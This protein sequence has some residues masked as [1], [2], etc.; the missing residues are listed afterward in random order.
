LFGW[1]AMTTRSPT[2]NLH[3]SAVG[4]RPALQAVASRPA[5]KPVIELDE[6]RRRFGDT[7][8]LDGVSLTIASGEVHALLGPNG[9]GKTTLIRLLAGLAAPTGGTLRLFGETR[10]RPREL[11]AR[12][13]FV[14]SG[15]RTFYLRLSGLEN[16]R[17][18]ARLHGFSRR[19][20][21]AV[22]RS[23]L[24]DVGLDHAAHRPV[25]SW[26][27]G[28]QK[29]LSIARALVTDP[30][31]LLVDEAT[32]DLDPEASETV[33]R[34]VS[35]LAERGTAVLWATQRVDEIRGFAD[36]VTFLAGGTVRFSGS[37][38]HLI[39]QGRS[40]RYVLR[41]RGTLPIGPVGRGTLQWTVGSA[42]TVS[43]PR[44][45]DPEHVI[46]EPDPERPLG[47]ALAALAQAGLTVVSCR[48]ERSEV[49]EAFLAL[50]AEGGR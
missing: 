12:V 34:L 8:A 44:P 41:L 27:H 32:H 23:V 10:A 14:P 50:A 36:A 30:E 45:E 19:E 42:A 3:D 46:L 26:S 18:F 1:R 7:L 29:R 39:A 48:Q 5:P 20:A 28:M 13:A 31:V 47:D 43:M 40:G 49:E 9:A 37:V 16:L 17:F 2:A 38:E 15:D 25:G 6:V 24:A 22:A 35:A 11:K 33:R 4:P 21:T